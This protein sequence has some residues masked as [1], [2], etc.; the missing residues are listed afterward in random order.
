MKQS[1]HTAFAALPTICYSQA[2]LE[3]PGDGEGQGNLAS[4]SPWG[5][6]ATATLETRP[7]PQPR[8]EKGSL[9][10]FSETA[11]RYYDTLSLF[12]PAH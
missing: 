6:T 9:T 5:Q 8:L 12:T 4:C 10:V 7:L 3:T 11:E 1:V 2:T